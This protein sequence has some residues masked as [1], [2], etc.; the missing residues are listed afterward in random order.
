MKTQRSCFF[1][2][3]P[4]K[5][6]RWLHQEE[7]I[8]NHYDDFIR[9]VRFLLNSDE[10]TQKFERKLKLFR[11]EIFNIRGRNF[12]QLNEIKENIEK[13]LRRIMIRTERLTQT[14]D[15]NGMVKEKSKVFCSVELEELENFSV[16]DKS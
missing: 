13:E 9:T 4:I 10:K 3:L 5:C 15:R 2:P 16:L 11:G 8:E 7:N 1:L 14:E 6:I 12:G